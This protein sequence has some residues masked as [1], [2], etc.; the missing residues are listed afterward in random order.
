MVKNLNAIQKNRPI[1]KYQD[2]SLQSTES[3]AQ[4][5]KLDTWKVFKRKL[6]AF[7]TLCRRRMLTF[8]WIQKRS[9]KGDLGRIRASPE[10]AQ[11]LKKEKKLEY[12]RPIPRRS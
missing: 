9:N 11:I 7:E 10:Q 5:W 2:Q 12:N 6:Q 4:L 3:N 8:P 1:A